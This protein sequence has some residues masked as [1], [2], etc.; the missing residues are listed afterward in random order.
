MT[1]LRPPSGFSFILPYTYGFIGFGAD[2]NPA[3]TEYVIQRPLCDGGQLMLGGGRITAA[4]MPHVGV[5]DD[6]IV[7]PAVV[8][9]LQ[10]CLARGINFGLEVPNE[11]DAEAAWSGIWAA[12]R[13]DAP[14]VGAVPQ[15]SPGLWICAAYS[16]HGMRNATLS[17]KAVVR[18]IL[19][20]G[21]GPTAVDA[22][23]QSHASLGGHS[24][25]LLGD[26]REDGDCEAIAGCR[27]TRQ[28]TTQ[29][30]SRSKLRILVFPFF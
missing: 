23:I 3:S 13:D 5:S 29:T 4:S 1:A 19:A 25:K 9:F 30:R 14:W 15:H 8:K 11:F 12:S 18:M 28:K 21:K 7:D 6:S 22:E 2:P 16:G 26:S 27:S 20:E 17:A 24:A 10:G